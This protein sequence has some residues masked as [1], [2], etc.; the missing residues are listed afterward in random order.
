MEYIGA[1]GVIAFCITFT[2]IM[3]LNSIKI[4]SCAIKIDDLF[5]SLFYVV[6]VRSLFRSE[7]T[8]QFKSLSR[9]VIVHVLFPASF[10]IHCRKLGPCAHESE[11]FLNLIFFLRK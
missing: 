9:Y 1:Y 6:R 7:V 5:Q 4:R 2:N 10:I 3:R 8:V 11:H